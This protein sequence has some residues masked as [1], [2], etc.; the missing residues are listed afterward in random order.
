MALEK[1][2][3]GTHAA[4]AFDFHVRAFIGGDRA[5]N[6]E[7]D[8]ARR[9]LLVVGETVIVVDVTDDLAVAGH[10]IAQRYARLDRLQ[11]ADELAEKCMQR[12]HGGLEA[13]PVCGLALGLQPRGFVVSETAFSR[14]LFELVEQ[15][16]GMPLCM[17]V[18]GSC[19]RAIQ[20]RRRT[21][22]A[23]TVTEKII[24]NSLARTPADRPVGRF[25]PALISAA[26]VRHKRTQRRR[27]CRIAVFR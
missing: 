16:H 20:I 15:P 11:L 25:G 14:F 26:A 13:S 8:V 3:H 23:F 4:H 10:V 19:T 5:G 7:G 21:L 6:L 9:R 27:D 12:V 22:S 2:R 18:S 17:T 24:G 1:A